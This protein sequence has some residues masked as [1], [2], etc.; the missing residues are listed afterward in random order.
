MG[1]TVCTIVTIDYAF[2]GAYKGTYSKEL[3]RSVD[4]DSY[5]IT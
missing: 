1:Y 3:L 5:R 4:N 2:K